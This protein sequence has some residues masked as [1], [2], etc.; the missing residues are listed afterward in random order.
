MHSVYTA[1]K[2]ADAAGIFYA[3]VPFIDAT[4]EIRDGKVA[5]KNRYTVSGAELI[6]ASAQLLEY[7]ADRLTFEPLSIALRGLPLTPKSVGYL[8]SL[9]SDGKGETTLDLHSGGLAT[10]IL[11]KKF[12]TGWHVLKEDK[13][14]LRTAFEGHIPIKEFIK[15]YWLPLPGQMDAEMM[16]KEQRAVLQK[17]LPHDLA[18]IKLIMRD[19]EGLFLMLEGTAYRIAYR[20]GKYGIMTPLIPDNEITHLTFRNGHVMMRVP[21]GFAN[22]PYSQLG[23]GCTRIYMHVHMRRQIL[24]LW[25]GIEI[26]DLPMPRRH[27]I[28]HILRRNFSPKTGTSVYGGVVRAKVGRRWK[29]IVMAP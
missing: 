29:P 3:K 5:G 1:S 16:S 19:H 12:Q 7:E 15:G 2:S 17:H 4:I 28:D 21:G 20:D 18:A 13:L 6:R 9:R 10:P 22:V 27:A 8:A 24:R 25:N 23:D 11:F 14:A 26:A